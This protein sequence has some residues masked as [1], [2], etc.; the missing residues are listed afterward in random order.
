MALRFLALLF[1]VLLAAGSLAA[2]EIATG[3]MLGAGYDARAFYLR[4][5]G[6]EWTKTYAGA[7]YQPDAAGRLMNL[8][9]AQALFH[10]E[11]LTEAPFDPGQN[12]ADVIRALDYWRAHG[13]L[14]I[15]VSLQGGNTGYG[16]QIPE[17]QRVNA[18]K[19]GPGKGLLVSAFQPDGSLKAE[20]CARLLRLARALDERRMILNL[21]YFYQGQDEVLESPAAIR[22]AVIQ[23]TDFLIDNNIRN[24]IIEI[25]NEVGHGGFDHQQY[26]SD[27]LAA[28]IRLAQSRF[29][30]KKAPFRLPVSASSLGNMRPPRGTAEAADLTII[31]GNDTPPEL[32]LRRMKEL[33]AD[34][35]LPG[36]LYMNEDD[37]GRE[38]T[39]TH[40]ERELASLDA[41]WSHGGSWGYMPWRQVQMFPFRHYL[42]DGPSAEA[43]YFRAVLKAIQRKVVAPA[44]VAAAGPVPAR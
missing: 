11:W 24:V 19:A 32:K 31:H 28:L 18:A 5:A 15:T 33:R 23:A 13:V 9:V 7:Q 39:L 44:S 16:T 6:G 26:I 3:K 30:A 2:V 8:R 20:W 21:A 41:I 34:P 14:A 36:P 27:D 1:L 29:E 22:N 10:D 12:T 43:E 4:D 40:L 42:P 37:N 38:A 17:I 25:A 35:S